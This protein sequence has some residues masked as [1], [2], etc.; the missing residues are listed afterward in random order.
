MNEVKWRNV[1]SHGTFQQ[2]SLASTHSF[3]VEMIRFTR[4]EEHEAEQEF[5]T[6]SN[7]RPQTTLLRGGDVE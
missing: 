4:W 2:S 1:P 6:D 5:V 7:A 3:G